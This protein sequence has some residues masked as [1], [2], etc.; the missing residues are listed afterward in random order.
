MNRGRIERGIDLEKNGFHKSLIE[1]TFDLHLQMI[2]C[3]CVFS[4]FLVASIEMPLMQK[5]QFINSFNSL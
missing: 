1:S 3:V 2:A 4:F 5:R